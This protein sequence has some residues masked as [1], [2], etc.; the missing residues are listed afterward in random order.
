MHVVIE[1][2]P[3]GLRMDRLIDMHKLGVRAMLLVGRR[4]PNAM[5]IVLCML[6]FVGCTAKSQHTI[7]SPRNVSS[8]NKPNDLSP[9]AQRGLHGAIPGSTTIVPGKSVGPLTL[10]GTREAALA[11]FDKPNEEY[12]FDENSLGPCR[13]T[14]L[15][16]NDLDHE[17][18][19]GI[20]IYAKDNQIYQI[21]ADTPRYATVN[22]ITSDSSP[23]DVR[24]SFPASKAYVLLHSASKV[25]GG[26]DLV[27][28]VDQ[29]SGIALNFY[30]N[31]KLNQRRV[32]SIIV[33]DPSIKFL[34]KG[35][36]SPPQEW[37]KLQPFSLEVP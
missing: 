5:L 36:I 33:F 9:L 2:G 3:P 34:P 18:R 16:W 27:Y 21:T 37:R 30:Y 22:G 31:R 7:L 6:T 29:A 24:R 26:K 20:F 4:Q 35:C 12:I 13:Y 1:K 25:V 10:G 11:L 14:E 23:E 8:T 17:D 28:W 19:W 15:H 32:A